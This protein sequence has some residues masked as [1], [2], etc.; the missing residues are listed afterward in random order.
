MLS[1][2]N[3]F[4]YRQTVL[5]RETADWKCFRRICQGH[6]EWPSEPL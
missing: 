1:G 6:V 5:R 2:P 4:Y 3:S